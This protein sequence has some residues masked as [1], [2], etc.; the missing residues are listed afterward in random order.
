MIDEKIQLDLLRYIRTKPKLFALYNKD[1]WDAHIGVA[2]DVLNV[3]EQKYGTQ[4][5]NFD[6]VYMFMSDYATSLKTDAETMFA[7]VSGIIRQAFEQPHLD[8]SYLQRVAV[9]TAQ[10]LQAFQIFQEHLIS[11]TSLGIDF[12]AAR[13]SKQL[14]KIAAID[15]N[16]QTLE[17]RR[18]FAD[19]AMTASSFTMHNVYKCSIEEINAWRTKGG[20]YAPEFYV[21]AAPH[22]ALKT[23]TLLCFAID[24]A[25]VNRMNVLYIDTEN[26]VANIH[27]RGAQNITSTTFSGYSIEQ[28]TQYAHDMLKEY[29]CDVY[30]YGFRPGQATYLDVEN[31][32]DDLAT[33]G[34]NIGLIVYDYAD[35]M[36]PVKQSKAD[37]KNA[38]QVYLD[39][40][41]V[42]MKYGT[43]AW[44]A[45]QIK[46][47]LLKQGKYMEKGALGQAVAKEHHAHGIFSL[48]GTKE[49][50]ALNLRRL[51]PVTQREGL[52]DDGGNLMIYVRVDPA[53]QRILGVVP[54][55]EVEAELEAAANTPNSSTGNNAP[56]FT[57]VSKTKFQNLD[58]K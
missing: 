26:G 42:N 8:V 58:D 11:M 17:R 25:L 45:S 56:Q 21:L 18:L 20:F 47:E 5:S 27:Q 19:I 34:I 50:R 54:R 40:I 30:I 1:V 29:N 57:F 3:Y 9:E 39:L 49:E 44:T 31:I 51:A 33:Q 43:M 32:L 12:D 4:P 55:D 52:E 2:F 22:K 46:A 23:M 48:L 35:N 10:K 53:T 37:H 36:V 7:E 13:L 6:T 38:S 28:A 41:G 14:A 15:S 16:D 24:F